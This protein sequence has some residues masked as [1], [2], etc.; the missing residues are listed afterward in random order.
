ME[1]FEVHILGCGSAKPTLR[2][3]PSSQIINVREKV[4]MVDCGEGAQVQFCRARQKFSRLNAI[5]ISHLHGDHVFGLIGLLSTMA[6]AGR[7]ATLHIYAHA[8]LQGLLQPHIDFFCR[9]MQYEVIFHSLPDD[10]DSHLIYEDRSI[11]VHTL[12][13]CHRLPSCGF[14]FKE[15]PL[16]PHIRHDMMTYLQIPYYMVNT[17]KQGAGWTDAEGR[18]YRHEELVTP[19]D[20]PRSYAYCSD[21]NFQ[22]RLADMLQGVNVLYHEATFAHDMLPRA[23]ETCHSTARQAGEMARLAQ[24]RRLVIG[25]FSSRYDD[26]QP[27]LAEAQAVFPNTQLAHEGMVIQ[28][29]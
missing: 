16:L 20:A 24:A 23:Q 2:H 19:A 1:K 9:G 26:E 7:T 28:V 13:L 25:H 11:E 27:L 22:P 18:T 29:D 4:F 10:H 3:Q 14:L 8:P 21:T 15:K 12:P 5:F 17:I 6:L